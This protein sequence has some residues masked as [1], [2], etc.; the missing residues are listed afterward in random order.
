MFKKLTSLLL[1]FAML[2]SLGSA[3][4]EA[5]KLPI[6]EKFGDIKLKVAV[7]GDPAIEDWETNAYVK[8]LEEKTN[9]DLSFEVIPEEGAAEKLGLILASGNYPDVFLSV[10]I[11]DGNIAKYGIEEK[12]FLPLN[13]LIGEHGNNIKKMFE[14]FPGA[15]AR[16]TQL[17]GEIYSLPDVNICYHC[18][19]RQKYWINS[20][21]LEKLGL[22]KPATTEEF[23]KVL[24]AFRDQDPNGNGEKDELPMIANYDDGWHTNSDSFVMNAFTYYP[25]NLRKAITSG[26]EGFG[27]YLDKGKVVSCLNDAAGMKA[28]L[29]FISKLVAEGLFYEG[30][31]SQN[32][33][34][35]MIQ[36]EG[37]QVGGSAGGYL[38]FCQTGSEMYQ[39]YDYL[40]PLTGP[41]GQRNMTSFP[42]EGV[43]GHRFVISA[44]TEHPEAALRLADLMY[45]FDATIRGY[46]GVY[47]E[48]W[49][50]PDPGAVGLNGEPALYKVLTP[51]QDVNAQNNSVLQYTISYRDAAFRNGEQT[52]LEGTNK[53]SG[54][55]LEIWLAEATKE[56]EA[57]AD[58]EKPLP[59]LKFDT[60][61]MEELSLLSTELSS[62]VKEGITAFMTGNSDV[63][64]YEQWLA[65]AKTLGLDKLI[66]YYQAAYD[67]QY[68]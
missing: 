47:G 42:H 15:R 38:Q 50:D 58:K 28:G 43:G 10:G 4:A 33:A 52:D 49:T 41:D 30:S 45:S 55:G 7:I 2:L 62:Y 44:K 8:W 12:L 25:L 57:V 23:Y 48:N 9:I 65:E 29:A 67:A 54:A 36:G 51:W 39:Q 19:L 31:F 60:A 27:L 22:E 68:K 17:D 3:L 6:A 66:E 53:K 13:A 35:D 63:E 24:V 37:G 20:V 34:A 56:Y 21:W 46:H 14:A 18:G 26:A 61:T 32:T 40:L 16:M 5:D 64:Q 59:P 1:C 11:S